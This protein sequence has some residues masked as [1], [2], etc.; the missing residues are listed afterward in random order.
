MGTAAADGVAAPLQLAGSNPTVVAKATPPVV[1]VVED[2]E[3]AEPEAPAP[4]ATRKAR[5]KAAEVLETATIEIAEPAVRS[6]A[7][8]VNAVPAGNSALADIVAGWDDSDE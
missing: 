6:T 1:P 2:M 7:A 3:D 5:P 8:K 4:K